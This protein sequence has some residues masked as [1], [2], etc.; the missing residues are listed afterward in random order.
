[1]TPGPITELWIDAFDF[2]ERGGWKFDTQFAH[3]TGGAFLIAA[4]EPGVPV[5]DAAS[6]TRRSG[7]AQP[8]THSS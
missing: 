7:S 3:L 2:K 6:V 1:M 8:A 4:D 5:Q